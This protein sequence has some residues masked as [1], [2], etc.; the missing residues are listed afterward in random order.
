M[1]E[2]IDERPPQ[3]AAALGHQMMQEALR[4]IAALLTP[5]SAAPSAALD[6]TE[7]LLSA[8]QLVGRA[9]DV[10][11]RAPRRRLSGTAAGDPVEAIAHASHLRASRVALH[12]GW[13]RDDCGPLLAFRAE[14]NRP[15]V[16]IPVRPGR[17]E[18]HDPSTGERLRVDATVA[19]GLRADAY[20][21]V[22]P[23][24]DGPLAP[25]QLARFG[26]RGAGRDIVALLGAGALVA[27]L[28]MIAPLLTQVIIDS[29]IPSGARREVLLLSAILAVVALAAALLQVTRNLAAARI[30]TRVSVA[31][32]SA[33]WDRL[34][35][36]PAPFFR[37]YSAGSLATRAMAIETIRQFLSSILVPVLLPAGFALVNLLLLAF[38]DLW[39]AALGLALMLVVA[40]VTALVGRRLVRHEHTIQE[41][42]P[43]LSGL[44]VQLI[45]SIPRLR[46]AKAE[47]RAFAVWATRFVALQRSVLKVRQISALLVVFA[48]VVPVLSSMALFG[49]V[50]LGGGGRAYSSGTFVAFSA[51]FNGLLGAMLLLSVN[52]YKLARIGA[53]FAQQRPILQ[54]P[55]EAD[56]ARLDPGALSG[57]L[58]ISHVTFR[59]QPDG[60]DILSDVTINARPGEFVAIVGPSGSGKSTLIRLLLG[61][62]APRTGAIYYDEQNLADLDQGAVRRQVGVVLQHDQLVPGTI[63]DNIVGLS[64]LTEGDAWATAEMV[65]LADDIRR[66][67][68]GMQTVVN[69]ATSTFSGGQLQRL[70][71]ARAIAPRP[72]IL[73][74]DEATSALDNRTQA[75]VMRGLGQL[76]ATRIVIAHRLSTIVQADR[77]YVLAGGKV[78][79]QGTYAALLE[80]DGAFRE[81]VRR[82]QLGEWAPA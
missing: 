16:L 65:G 17:Y 57:A 19:A 52:I 48:T 21:F 29:L 14:S 8:C 3:H 79:Q 67:P 62:E 7:A 75:L 50:A 5:F 68:L 76:R 81:L 53:L 64:L 1:Q 13:W 18:L 23:L 4:Q 63:A 44:V 28:G 49:V 55:Q 34:L 46:I 11:I 77:I 30:E 51:A 20:L 40:G 80:T 78:V 33:L 71:L 15:V 2:R 38:F 27:L 45:Q 43:N 60:P 72:A 56:L 6:P 61:F 26:L 73:L 42:L 32:Q 12:R 22:R 66:L 37:R 70:L 35:K 36:L 10:S 24:P 39:L 74:F 82:Q 9:A 58:A 47:P 54:A 69:E 41:L 59:Y 31:M 25:S